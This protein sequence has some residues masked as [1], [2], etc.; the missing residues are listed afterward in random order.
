MGFVVVGLLIMRGVQSFRIQIHGKLSSILLFITIVM[1][2][3]TF[4]RDRLLTERVR[5]DGLKS[6]NTDFLSTIDIY[7]FDANHLSVPLFNKENG[8]RA[9]SNREYPLYFWTYFIGFCLELQKITD[10]RL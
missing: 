6:R 4:F 10:Q 3:L 1:L 9:A 8:P 2:G 7:V 5:A